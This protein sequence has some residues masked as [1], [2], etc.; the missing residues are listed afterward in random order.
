MSPIFPSFSEPPTQ[1]QAQFDE[2]ISSAWSNQEAHRPPLPPPN[3]NDSQLRLQPNGQPQSP[4]NGIL[5]TITTNE[6]PNLSIPVNTGST[7][8]LM[9]N[10]VYRTIVKP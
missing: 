2:F 3:F 1:E 5:D 8:R 10:E 9:P 4:W 7:R 6:Q